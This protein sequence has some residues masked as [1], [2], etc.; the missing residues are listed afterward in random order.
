[1]ELEFNDLLRKGDINPERVLVLRHR[2]TEPELRK[3]LPWLASEHPDIFNAYQATQNPRAEA[4]M[5]R[6][7]HVAAFIG[8]EP[9]K[10]VFVGLYRQCGNRPINSDDFQK[11]DAYKELRKLGMRADS[12]D[13]KSNCLLFDLQLL[14]ILSNWRGRLIVRWPPPEI[15]WFRWADRNQ[16]R[17][18]AILDESAFARA[19]PDWKDIVLSWAEL[20]LMPARWRAALQQW[21][22][23]YFIFDTAR[24]AGYVGSAS[25]GDNILGRWT[26][27]AQSGHG[28]NKRLRLSNPDDLRFSILELTSPDLIPKDVVAIET[29]WKKRLHTQGYQMNEPG[30]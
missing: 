9:G 17:V 12:A 25:G 28:G 3:A 13:T 21:R 1:M 29:R 5:S 26:A 2:P 20:R 30:G 18:D 6:A 7:A 27:Y 22:G 15:G 11:S 14:E 8:H 10:A 16:M 4:A 24:C 23:V 19:M